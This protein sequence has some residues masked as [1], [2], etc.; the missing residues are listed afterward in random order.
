MTRMRLSSVSCCSIVLLFSCWLTVGCTVRFIADYDSVLDQ[1]MTSL[2]QSSEV[3][4]TQLSNQG[5]TAAGNYANNV[6]FYVRT[7]ATLTTMATRVGATPKSKEVTTQI[8]LLQKSFTDMQNDHK[9]DGNLSADYLVHAKSAI[10][11]QFTSVTTLELFLK[12][13]PIPSSALAPAK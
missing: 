3:F 11:S 5:N 10:E 4:F 7:Q 12:N 13:N 1:N 9:R 6:D 2:Q 8:Q